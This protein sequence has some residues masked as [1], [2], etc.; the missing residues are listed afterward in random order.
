MPISRT[1]LTEANG[2]ILEEQGSAVIQDLIAQS[3]V[4][5]FARREAMASRTKSV[6]RF[7]GDAPQVVAEGAEIPAS[8]PTLDEIVLTARKYA[9]LMHI[10]EE[11][12]ND[13]LVDTLSVYKR[14]WAS[15]FARKFDNACLG[16]TAAGDGDDGQPFTS[17]YRALATSPTAPV[18]QIIQTGGAM[19]YEDIN[20]ALGFV[21]NSKKFDAANTVWMAHPKMLKEIRG[22]IKGNNDLVLP[23]PLAGTPGSLFGYPL[24]VSYGAATSTAAT[25]SPTGN[26]LLIVGNR[27]MLINGVRGGVESVVSRDAEFDRDGV[28]LKTR[29][30][31]GF[32]VADADA[33]AIVEKTA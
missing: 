1:D 6:P 17:L 33:F 2:Y 23:D 20:N 24:V 15:R 30:R 28:V 19:S 31:R 3:A 32:A 9:Q 16:V 25:D 7:V 13:S 4:E 11:D 14:E 27:Q 10:S 26:A 29:I 5:R 21:E 22:M 12:V 8:N 18:S